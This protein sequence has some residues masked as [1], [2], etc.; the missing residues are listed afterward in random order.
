MIL[1]INVS[2]YTFFKSNINFLFFVI[3]LLGYAYSQL[4]FI[5]SEIFSV[6]RDLAYHDYTLLVL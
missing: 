6:L 5:I 4:N 1:D 2:L 3:N